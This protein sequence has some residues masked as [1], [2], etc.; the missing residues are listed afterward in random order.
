MFQSHIA[1]P[2]NQNNW[3]KENYET[4]RNILLFL[5]ENDEIEF[6]LLNEKI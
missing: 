6:K 5:T 3:T 2:T 4:F 1:G